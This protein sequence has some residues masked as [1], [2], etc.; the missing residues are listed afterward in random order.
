MLSFPRT[1]LWL[2]SRILENLIGKLNFYKLIS[3]LTEYGYM[4]AQTGPPNARKRRPGNPPVGPVPPSP[5]TTG[6]M[7]PVVVR[8]P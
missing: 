7:L 1:F 6:L 3:Y 4:P 2:Y 5:L 8:W